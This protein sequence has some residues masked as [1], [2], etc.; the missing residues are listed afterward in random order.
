M[1]RARFGLALAALAL[2]CA[3]PGRSP[4]PR[5]RLSV[6]LLEGFHEPLA[7]ELAGATRVELLL[8][9]TASMRTEAASGV[10]RA[11]LARRAA[12]R[13]ASALGREVE[14]GARVLGG[15]AG[16]CR[17]PG[18][19]MVA[20]A[21]ESRSGWI[22]K[23]GAPA[24]AGEGSLAEALE[25]LRADLAPAAA[26][27]DLRVAVF[28]DLDPECGGDLCSAL[29]SLVA[30]GA[31]VD[32]V[33]VGDAPIPDCARGFL[34][35]GRPRLAERSGRAVAPRFTVESAAEPGADPPRVIA[36]ARADGVSRSLP[37]G[38]GVVLVELDPPLR[39]G[40]LALEPA[41]LT[42][43]RIL[44]FPQLEPPVREWSLETLPLAPE[45]EPAAEA[46][47]R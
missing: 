41:R 5:A 31:L 17:E 26:A 38:P 25:A 23:L 40:P 28:T 44:D 19:R 13:F 42:R 39:I 15:R 4:E 12:E 22:E 37:A 47:G 34:A 9:L 24:P 3:L 29:S 46:A 18:E 43:L 6:E 10:T 2:A 45:A 27:G 11:L 36:A 33:A 35:E 21:G 16:S 7:A 30:A 32:L 8:D 20:R 1:R 14:L